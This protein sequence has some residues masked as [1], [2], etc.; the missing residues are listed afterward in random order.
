TRKIPVLLIMTSNAPENMYMKMLD[1][2]RNTLNN[3]IGPT[4]IMV[5]GETM[6]VKD[7]SK[8]NWT[9]FNGEERVKRRET[10]FPK[11]LEKA[12][13]LGKSLV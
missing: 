10:V 7:Y 5:S 6:Q 1:G 12:F 2:Y 8:F 9:F 4:Q 13:A 3:F 11:E